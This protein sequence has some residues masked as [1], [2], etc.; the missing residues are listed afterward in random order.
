[1]SVFTGGV[2]SLWTSPAC[3]LRVCSPAT[4]TTASRID[5]FDA[6]HMCVPFATAAAIRFLNV[7]VGSLPSTTD[8]GQTA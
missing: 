2:R 4:R 8:I 5:D 6:T 3:A 1:M 7:V